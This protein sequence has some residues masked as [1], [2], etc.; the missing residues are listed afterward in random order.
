MPQ[1]DKLHEPVK[2]ALQ[3]AGWTVTHDPYSVSFE[4]DQLYIDLAAEQLLAA[5]QGETR[6]AVEVKGFLGPSV[7]ADVQQAIGQ[8]LL[9]RSILARTDPERVLILAVSTETERDVFVRPTVQ[10][11]LT[12]HAVRCLI[13]DATNEEIVRW[14][15]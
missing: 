9:Y 1:R 6:I 11:F 8:Y 5:E 13:V 12:D 2:R 3:R 10:V 14:K 4:G 7:I 15:P